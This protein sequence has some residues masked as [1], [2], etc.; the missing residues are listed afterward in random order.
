MKNLL[1][2]IIPIICIAVMATACYFAYA[3]RVD[4]PEAIYI[5]GGLS[6]GLIIIY[7]V[8]ILKNR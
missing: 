2:W 1:K 8:S 6:I 3:D 7:I 4:S 5:V